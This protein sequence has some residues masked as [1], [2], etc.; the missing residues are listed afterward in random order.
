[1]KSA[2]RFRN[3]LGPLLRWMALAGFVIGGYLL[4]RWAEPSPAA[5]ITAQSTGGSSGVTIRLTKTPFA[6]YVDGVKTWSLWA[7]SVEMDHTPNTGLSNVQSATLTDIRD[8]ILFI[9]EDAPRAPSVRTASVPPP[10]ET[11]ESENPASIPSRSVAARFRAKQGRYLLGAQEVLPLELRLSYNLQ[12]Q[13]KL[14]GEVDF[15]T[16]G[17]RLHAPAITVYALMNR[18]TGKPEQ[19]VV[20]EEGAKLSKQGA[21]VYANQ[22]RYNPAD[23]VVECL[24]G[25]RGTFK[26]VTMQCERAF[27]SL[28]DEVVRCPETVSGS[29]KDMPFTADGVTLDL[30][31]GRHHANHIHIQPRIEEGEI[32]QLP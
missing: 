31:N 15:K 10:V 28:K 22:L 18:R 11:M 29:F 23:Q 1:M 12:W 30:K 5:M 24:G 4:Y 9:P 14:T 6:G 7:G 13:L 25:A 32:P 21:L 17:E 8:G 19:R 20:C 27:F 3:L 16:R 26:G 2:S